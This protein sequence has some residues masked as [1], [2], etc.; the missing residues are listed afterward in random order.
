MI[1]RRHLLGGAGL[2]ATGLLGV[3]CASA[4]PEGLEVHE[5]SW[6]DVQRDR[7]VLA[8]LTL[9]AERSGSTPRPLVVISP[10]I[11][12]NRF[13]YSYLAGG[14]AQRGWACLNLEHVGSNRQVWWGNPWSLVDRLQHAAREEEALAR[15]LDLRFALDQVLGASAWR[16]RVDAERVVGAGHSYGANTLMLAAG[17]G[18]RR[19]G[20][21]LNLREPRLKA[22][23]LMSAP[24]FYGEADVPAVVGGISVPNLHITTTEDVIKIPGYLSPVEDR[25]TLYQHMGGA[26]KG[27]LVFKGAPTASSPTAVRPGA[28]ATTHRSRRPPRRSAT[29]GWRRHCR[30]RPPA[31]PP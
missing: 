3:G 6:L 4:L 10:G 13:G 31:P 19:Q 20:Q 16:G 9:P 23:V 1:R 18:V 30:A 24:P 7:P 21:A 5:L 12:S 28:S 27:L 8:R 26:R 14:L 25:L 22:V 11:G 2:A 15:V 17:A 29:C